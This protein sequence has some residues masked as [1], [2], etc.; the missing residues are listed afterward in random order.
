MKMKVWTKHPNHFIRETNKLLRSKGYSKVQADELLNGDL[1]SF[2]RLSLAS[3]N[4]LEDTAVY[5]GLE[6]DGRQYK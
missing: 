1:V 2:D 6:Y 3:F 4:A 5:M